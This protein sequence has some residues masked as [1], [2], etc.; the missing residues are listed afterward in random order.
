MT[1]DLRRP[2][3]LAVDAPV[4]LLHAAR[5][6]RD[7]EVE[8]VGAVVLEIDALATGIGRHQDAQRMTGRIGVEG[9]LDS[10]PALFADAPVEGHD[11]LTVAIGTG[12]SR[13]EL[14]DEIPLRVRVLG[15]DEHAPVVPPCVRCAEARAEVRLHPGEEM[16]DPAVGQIPGLVGDAG[17][18]VEQRELGTHLVGRTGGCGRSRLHLGVVLG[19]D[20]ILL[21]LRPLVIGAERRHEQGQGLW[22]DF[23]CQGWRASILDLTLHRPAVNIQGACERFDR[24]KQA[25]LKRNHH[26]Q[27]RCPL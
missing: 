20:L 15:E 12:D 9:G 5:V 24:G 4:A 21:Q 26:Q 6:P 14:L 1:A 8:Q 16:P 11:P 13:L 18:L 10:L 23:R 2:L 7:V 27:G 17:H 19:G 25:L 22:A 3:Q